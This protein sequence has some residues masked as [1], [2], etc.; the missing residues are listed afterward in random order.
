[1]TKYTWKQHNELV[2]EAGQ[3]IASL[4]L[5]P[6]TNAIY[7]LLHMITARDGKDPAKWI[8]NNKELLKRIAC[9]D[10]ISSIPEELFLEAKRTMGALAR[11]LDV[12][13]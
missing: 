8:C 11:K 5:D 13:A 7:D 2:Q 9:Y 3:F 6:D 12:A 10:Y 4:D 1:M